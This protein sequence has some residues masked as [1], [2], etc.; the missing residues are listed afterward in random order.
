MD[1]ATLLAFHRREPVGDEGG[2]GGYPAAPWL[3][4][5]LILLWLPGAALAAEA[6]G[7][8][9]PWSLESLAKRYSLEARPGEAGEFL[10]TGN[11]VKI[12]GKE[13]DPWLEI[14]RLRYRL[15]AAWGEAEEGKLSQSD[16]A[17]LLDPLLQPSWHIEAEPFEEICLEPVPGGG[18]PDPEKVAAMLEAVL[19]GY[20]I[21]AR[22]AAAGAP[23]KPLPWLR[24]Q[25][26][27][28]GNPEAARCRILAHSHPG[29]N[30]GGVAPGEF[31]DAESLILATLIQTGLALGPGAKGGGAVDGG[32]ERMPLPEFAGIPA[33][34]VC[35]EWGSE[36]DPGHIVKSVAAGVLRFRRYLG[37]EREEAAFGRRQIKLTRVDLRE[38]PGAGE[39]QLLLSVAGKASD[40]APDAR[41]GIEFPSRLFVQDEDGR[42]RML[43]GSGT[44][45]EWGPLTQVPGD[46][47]AMITARAC[48]TLAE[49]DEARLRAGFWGYAVWAIRE[50]AV[51]DRKATPASL[52]DQLWRWE[53]R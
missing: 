26:A 4:A 6:Q 15:R 29:E 48:L 7:A 5:G 27:K 23:D 33:P 18:G 42:I 16:V 8:P 1:G 9:R 51:E 41:S 24:L 14:N 17:G 10:L 13:G 12:R 2:R 31:F 37:T 19:Q 45:V 47:S 36:V 39:V 22:H 34:A 35:V 3:C 21:K 52:V 46:E 53:G 38:G 11:G 30:G 50:G 44:R 28:E 25:V 49:G 32:I 20:E 43:A 40:L